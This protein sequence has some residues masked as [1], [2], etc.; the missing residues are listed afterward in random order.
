MI[1]SE[2]TEEAEKMNTCEEEK[3]TGSVKEAEKKEANEARG[4]KTE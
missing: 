1:Y 3:N 4:R 2:K